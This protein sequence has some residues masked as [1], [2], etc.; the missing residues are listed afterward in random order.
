M[1]V[2]CFIEDTDKSATQHD[3][4]EDLVVNDSLIYRFL[5]LLALKTTKRFYGSNGPC[6]IISPHLIIKRGPFAH[7]TEAAT[8]RYLAE[9]T[10]IPVP[11]LHCAFVHNNRASIVMERLQ[12][13]TL[14]VAWKSLS[15]AQRAAIFEQLK[16]IFRELRSLPPPPGVGIESCVGGSLRDSRIPRSSPRFGPFKTVQEFHLWLREDLRPEDHPNRKDD[17]DWKDIKRM[18]A[19]QDGPWPP[20]VFTHGDLHPSNIMVCGD[21][22]TGIIDWEFAG[23][24]PHYW[25]YTSAWYGHHT[26]HG[27]ENEILKFLDPYPEELEM[28]KTRQRWWGDF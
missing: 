27:W 5:S 16:S 4:T 11:R 19:K 8:L 18:V 17:Q 22:V 13:V 25:E 26:R 28:E 20:P 14:G 2:R 12:G 10:S 15:N 9:K 24:Y 23:W 3:G 6:A 1:T 7:L 21:C